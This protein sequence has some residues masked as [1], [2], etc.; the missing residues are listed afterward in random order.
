[1]M[2]LCVGILWARLRGTVLFVGVGE[3]GLSV[4]G[5]S[6]GGPVWEGFGFGF[7]FSFEAGGGAR[8]GTFGSSGNVW[9]SAGS[10]CGVSEGV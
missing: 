2:G 1:M 3:G 6:V 9:G 5:L 7:G 4:R 8:L 10:L